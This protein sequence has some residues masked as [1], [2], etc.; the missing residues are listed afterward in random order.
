LGNNDGILDQLIPY[1][2]KLHIVAG[3]NLIND[4]GVGGETSFRYPRIE[5]PNEKL[6]KP[7]ETTLAQLQDALPHLARELEVIQN[8]HFSDL[9]QVYRRADS[10]THTTK[11]IARKLMGKFMARLRLNR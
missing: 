4:I 2:K 7:L 5:V 8:K 11:F 9:W 10:V 3:S 6:D 1:F